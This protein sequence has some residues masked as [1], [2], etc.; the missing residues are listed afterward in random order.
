MDCRCNP[1]R[2]GP[3][4]GTLMNWERIF[5]DERLVGDL[6]ASLVLI[7]TV[8]IVRATAMRWVRQKS[9][10]SDQIQLRWTSQ[11]RT[12]SY[13][14]LGA[15]LLT[16]WAAELKSAALSLAAFAVAAVIAS[17][18]LILC[19][20]GAVLRASSDAFSVGDRV[21]IDGIR[22]DVID[23]GLLATTLMEVGCGHQR[24]GRSITIPNSRL[25]TAHVQNESVTGRYMFHVIRLPVSRSSD[26]KALETKALAA[27]KR[28]IAPFEREA[29]RAIRGSLRH[30]GLTPPPTDPRVT[31][32]P[33]KPDEVEMLIRI[34]APVQGLRVVE[35]SIIRAMLDM[36]SNRE[37]WDPDNPGMTNPGLTPMGRET[38]TPVEGAETKKP[39]NE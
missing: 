5:A 39:P 24:T 19:V 9:A 26:L 30:Y 22:G 17:K 16:I 23:H 12:L 7:F 21:E 28:A 6:S 11:I 34:P 18:E 20:L 37:R 10:Q 35:Q 29:A 1:R 38:G 4:C 8:A 2:A 33:T 13:F 25:L 31:F 32:Q 14:L 15:G 3:H 27:A 36:P